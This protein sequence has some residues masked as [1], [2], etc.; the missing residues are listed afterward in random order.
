MQ[1]LELKCTI[2]GMKNLV[3]GVKIKLDTPV[4]WNCAHKNI[5]IAVTKF[6][7]QGNKWLVENNTDLETC[8]TISNSPAYIWLEFQ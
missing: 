5:L 1:I 2:S 4:E 7:V 3:D 8:V 6:K